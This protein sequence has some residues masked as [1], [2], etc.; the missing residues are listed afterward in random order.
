MYISDNQ[1]AMSYDDFRSEYM[2]RFPSKVPKQRKIIRHYPWWLGFVVGLMFFSAAILS[3]VHTVPTTYSAIEESVHPF[4]RATAALASFMAVEIAIFVSAYMM[5][6]K[7]S[8]A[9]AWIVLILSSVVAVASNLWSVSKAL[10]DNSTAPESGAV[11]VIL[12]LGVCMPAI[13]LASGKLFVNIHRAERQQ[14]LEIDADYETKS[15]AMDEEIASEYQKYL[16]RLDKRTDRTSLSERT[17]SDGQRTDSGQ[18]S[19]YGYNRTADGKT[20]VINHLIE[21][22]DDANLNVRELGQRVGVG[23][24]T[25]AEG[26]AA[27]LS[28][29]HTNGSRHH[30]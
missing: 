23:K 5:V 12:I 4:V 27:Y 28:N 15:Q 11:I 1:N 18:V 19:G 7:D 20:K 24:S 14:S 9:L 25:A 8:R 3:G 17:T 2:R 6:T 10:S 13:A 16:S 29:G 21:N 22:P 30:D 26:K